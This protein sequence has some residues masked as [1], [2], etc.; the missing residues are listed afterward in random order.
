DHDMTWHDA[1]ITRFSQWWKRMVRS[2]HAFAEGAWLH[3]SPPERMWVWETR[4]A[5]LWA[6]VLP[7][8]IALTMTAISP[9]AAL[10][11]GVYPLQW[12]RQ[13][14]RTRSIRNSAFSLLGK[15]AE[16]QGILKFH[17]ERLRGVHGHIIEYK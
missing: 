6:G 15:F 10:L 1:N 12:L 13:Y 17:T 7:A 2:G 8:A 14:L 9:I 4:R 16:A 11:V 3:G 5:L